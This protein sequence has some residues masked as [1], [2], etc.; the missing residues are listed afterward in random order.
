MMPITIWQKALGILA[1][2]F[3]GAAFYGVALEVSLYRE[4][5]AY[6]SVLTGALVFSVSPGAILVAQDYLPDALWDG[7]V[8]TILGWPAWAVFGLP[9]IVLMALAFKERLGCLAK[10][11]NRRRF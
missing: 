4:N 5:G 8:V 2:A 6:E 7:V 9:G 1:A 11:L 10:S 3:L